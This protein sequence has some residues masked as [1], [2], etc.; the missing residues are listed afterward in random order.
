MGTQRSSFFSPDTFEEIMLPHYKRMNDA[1]HEMGLLVNFHSC[2]SVANQIDL[3]IEAGFDFWEGQDACNDKEGI[4]ASTE[5]K[6]GQ[7]SFL[8]LPATATDDEIKANLIHRIK[9]LG[10]YGRYILLL[11]GGNPASDFRPD[12]FL[13]EMSRRYYLGEEI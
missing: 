11:R 3:F 9:T 6:L 13:Y 7:V 4:M 2:G 12:H 5:G 10:A 1:A 8:T